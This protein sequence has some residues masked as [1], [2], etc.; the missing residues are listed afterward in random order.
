MSLHSHA[1]LF[2]LD[3]F[4]FFP[5]TRNKPHLQVTSVNGAF[6]KD[7]RVGNGLVLPLV[8]SFF[9]LTLSCAS[10]VPVVSDRWPLC[11]FQPPLSVHSLLGPDW[12]GVTMTSP[13]RLLARAL[14]RPFP[15]DWQPLEQGAILVHRL[16]L[17]GR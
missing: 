10:C 3:D 15:K 7:K 1:A 11:T 12:V 8:T 6:C 2:S 14:A 9:T 16:W 17:I 13:A 4:F 5:D